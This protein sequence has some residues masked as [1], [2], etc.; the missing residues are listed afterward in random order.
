MFGSDAGIGWYICFA[1][2][3]SQLRGVSCSPR[4]MPPIADALEVEH[5]QILGAWSQ[6]GRCRGAKLRDQV[7][8]AF[9]GSGT[10][11]KREL[12]NWPRSRRIFTIR[13]RSMRTAMRPLPA[14]QPVDRP[15][16]DGWCKVLV[17]FMK[18]G[19][20]RSVRTTY[21]TKMSRPICKQYP[22]QFPLRCR[23]DAAAVAARRLRGSLLRQP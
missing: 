12:L 13:L 4:S 16:P 10:I 17:Q 8:D 6:V 21:R 7:H 19:L 20:S 15:E 9:F 23:L 18:A 14:L 3:S 2:S 1:A 11:S 22:L 5:L